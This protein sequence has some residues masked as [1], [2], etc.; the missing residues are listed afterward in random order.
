MAVKKALILTLVLIQ[1]ILIVNPFP[2]Q[3]RPA[4][5]LVEDPRLQNQ[6]GTITGPLKVSAVNPR[7]FEDP[8]GYHWEIVWGPMFDFAE[9]GTLRFRG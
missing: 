6:A 4:K 9:D 2:D 3:A 5:A 1:I 8:D 7:Y